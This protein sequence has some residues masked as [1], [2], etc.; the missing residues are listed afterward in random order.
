MVKNNM[1]HKFGYLVDNVWFCTQCNS[2][3][4][5]TLEQCPECSMSKTDSDKL[6]VDP[7]G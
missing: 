7:F 1:K 5:A 2:L 6:R 3:N 4:A